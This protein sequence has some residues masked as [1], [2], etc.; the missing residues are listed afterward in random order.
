MG[1]FGNNENELESWWNEYQAGVDQCIRFSMEFAN[2]ASIEWALELTGGIKPGV[3]AGD[4]PRTAHRGEW[5]DITSNLAN[6]YTSDV[7][8]LS[9]SEWLAW[10]GNW[11]EYAEHLENRQG[12][13]VISGIYESEFFQNTFQDTFT[14][15]LATLLR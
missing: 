5:A 10:V 12:F 15:C 14:E 13:W 9:S 11:M 3:R 2:R 4:G 6:G 7:Q 8:R 1:K